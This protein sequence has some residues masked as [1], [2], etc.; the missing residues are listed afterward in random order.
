MSTLER[1]GYTG[2]DRKTGSLIAKA[3]PK[4][5]NRAWRVST[6][7]LVEPVTLDEL[8][9]FARIDDDE[10]VEDTLLEGFIQAARTATESY[11]GRALIE[12]T[13]DMKMDW[14]P[15]IVVELPQPPLISITKV[16]TLNEADVETEYDSDNYYVITE[17][18]PGK[19]VL[20]QS[21]TAPTNTARD[22]G[23]YL[24]RYKAGYGPDPPDVPGPIREGI[25][26]WASVI[27]ATRVLD[28][29]NPPPEARVLL[30]LYR[31]AGV[32][33]R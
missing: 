28:S 6:A 2:L 7:P 15:G 1:L 24:V 25:K 23:G 21:V 10:G 17:A 14:W 3:L 16:A 33:I 26:L 29:K 13:I 19:L 5:G 31:M 12:Q 27:Q 9:T 32:M 20:K 4:H 11:L 22:Y 30:D 18:M 8:R